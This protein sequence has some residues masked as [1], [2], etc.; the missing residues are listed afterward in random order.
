MY[1]SFH[2]LQTCSPDEKFS[3]FLLDL[4]G[5]GVLKVVALLSDVNGSNDLKRSRLLSNLST[6]TLLS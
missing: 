1:P 5:A 2:H 6:P 3:F 4:G